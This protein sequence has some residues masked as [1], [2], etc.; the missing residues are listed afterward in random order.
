VSAVKPAARL[1]RSDCSDAGIRRVK[2]GRG[3]RYLDAAGRP[4][5]DHAALERIHALTIPPA[6]TDVWICGDPAGHLQATGIDAAGRKQYLY[7][8]LWTR[9]REREKFRRML[10][11]GAALPKLRRRVARELDGGPPTRERVL[12][13]AVRLLDIGLF[14]IGGEEYAD[15]NGG[16]GLATLRREH[17]RVRGQTIV[18]DYPAKSGVRR[19]HEIADPACC[20]LVR[21]LQRRRGGEQL[22]AY[23]DGRRWTEIRSDDI[24]EHVKGLIGDGFSAKDFRT[25][26]AT[27]LA[28][29]D[30][31]A[32]GQEAKSRSARQRVI[33]RAVKRVAES[34]GNTPAVAR[35]AYID[36]RI[37]DRFLAGHTIAG[38]M[39]GGEPPDLTGERTRKRLE[40]ALLDLLDSD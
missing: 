31:A 34:L 12:A 18:F 17:V 22:L 39:R 36:P 4:L 13:G 15:E 14:R 3:F 37:F 21:Q 2:S 24:N 40:A 23:R 29:V 9:R 27:L 32:H 26:N 38:A 5:T 30:L 11:F 35:R 7:H 1:R 6:W 19:V 33:A 20:A 25:W 8:S 10:A 16:I 28:A